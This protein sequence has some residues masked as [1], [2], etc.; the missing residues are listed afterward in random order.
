[1]GVAR[2]GR[3]AAALS[4][5]ASGFLGSSFGAFESV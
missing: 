3:G 1:M 5:P 4:L 2:R